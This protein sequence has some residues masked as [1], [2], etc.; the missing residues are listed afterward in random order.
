MNIQVQSAGQL[1]PRPRWPGT[2]PLAPLPGQICNVRGEFGLERETKISGD[3]TTTEKAP[4]RAFEW[5]RV[6]PH[7]LLHPTGEK[8]H[9]NGFLTRDDTCL[10]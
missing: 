2:L 10:A 6:L 3:F 4:I 5:L 7:A 9:G 1:S 8:E